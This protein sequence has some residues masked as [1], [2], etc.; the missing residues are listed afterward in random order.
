MVMQACIEDVEDEAVMSNVDVLISEPL[1][2]MLFNERML[3]S[4]IIARD[5][6]LKKGGKMFPCE[7]D[8]CVAPFA[9]EELYNDRL[10][11]ASFWLSTNF[12]GFDLSCLKDQAAEEKFR[13]PVMQ[14]Y[15]GQ[16][17]YCFLRSSLASEARYRVDFTTCTVS[18]LK[19]IDFSFEFSIFRGGL[20]HGIGVWFEALFV[21][22][23]KTV[24]L[25]TSPFAPP[26][27]WY[28]MRFLLKEPLTV[29]KGQTV[30]GN[31]KLT[32]NKQQSYSMKLTLQLPDVK[33]ESK[34]EYDIKDV[35]FRFNVYSPIDKYFTMKKISQIISVNSQNT[36]P[37]IC[38]LYTSPS[39]RD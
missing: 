12:Y 5:N 39:P 24:V 6:F 37:Y 34:G 38:L 20:I 21:G 18:E 10:A 8:F 2:N 3:E 16:T 19:N 17:Q 30:K 28:Q 11:K 4:Y 29:S 31:I 32:A 15:N 1:G 36:I 22:S 7:A 14:C 23:Q 35:D 9:D 25:S 13:Q 26:T 33:A 27:H